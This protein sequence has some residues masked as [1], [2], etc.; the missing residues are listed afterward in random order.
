MGRPRKAQADG[1]PASMIERLERALV[2]I[3]YIVVRHGSVY[4]PYIDR[5]QRE[6]EAAR[7]NE[8]T[9]R[10]KRILEAYAVEGIEHVNRLN[11]LRS[12]SKHD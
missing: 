1:A 7:Q 4:A 10:A 2:L 6:L 3:A 8:P 12:R 9:A 11:R 5:L